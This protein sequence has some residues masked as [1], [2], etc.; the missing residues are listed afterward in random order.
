MPPIDFATASAIFL[1]F[2]ARARLQLLLTL[3]APSPHR[4]RAS[5][6]GHDSDWR[7]RFLPSRARPDGAPALDRCRGRSLRDLAL[8]LPDQLCGFVQAQDAADLAVRYKRRTS[9]VELLAL[10]KLR[11]LVKT[12]H[13]GVKPRL[14]N[15]PGIEDENANRAVGGVKVGQPETRHWSAPR[16]VDRLQVRN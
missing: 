12:L 5:S 11:P 16:S 15:A 13:S 7:A 2:E 4:L 10:M 8:E 6:E 9:L 14:G 3:A 1:A